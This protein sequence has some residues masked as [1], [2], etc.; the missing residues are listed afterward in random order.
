MV[1]ADLGQAFFKDEIARIRRFVVRDGDD[2]PPPSSVGR[3]L[4]VSDDL[5]NSGARL[6]GILN[7]YPPKK[8]IRQRVNAAHRRIPVI[9][10]CLPVTGP[11]IMRRNITQK[12]RR[13]RITLCV[14][15]V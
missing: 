5:L 4:L 3:P 10:P 6:V 1:L 8:Q 7:R 15:A 9:N 13:F 11:H 12:L 14:N 2:L